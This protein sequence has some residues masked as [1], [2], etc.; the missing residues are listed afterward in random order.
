MKNSEQT[1][2]LRKLRRLNL[3]LLFM[4]AVLCFGPVFETQFHN[5]CVS[6]SGAILLVFF[7]SQTRS[8]ISDIIVR[9]DLLTREQDSASKE[10]DGF[11]D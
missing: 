3:L 5:P 2:I 7:L 10:S 8:I 4:P 1:N 9:V 6:I 11:K